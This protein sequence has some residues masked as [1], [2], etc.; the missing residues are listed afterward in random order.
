MTAEVRVEGL[1]ELR[2][3]LASATARLPEAIRQA[4]AKAAEKVAGQAKTMG[5][6]LGS[7]AAKAARSITAMRNEIVL[8]EPF[9]WGAEKGAVQFRQ[10][11]AYVGGDEAGYFLGP[12]VAKTDIESLYAQA[13]DQ[14]TRPA[15]PS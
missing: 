10:F 6:A 2:S 13:V 15:F 3:G 5:Q 12:A 4:D 9:G 14:A 11:K 8:D 1:S 7:V